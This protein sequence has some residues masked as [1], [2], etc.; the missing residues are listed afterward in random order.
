MSH[1]SLYALH[2]KAS[3]QLLD[4]LERAIGHL[5]NRAEINLFFNDLLTPT[6]RI[7]LSKRL[8]IILMIEKR[9][10]FSQIGSTLKVSES[11]I[12]AMRERMDRG[13]AGFHLIIRKLEKD[14]QVKKF[15]ENIERIFKALTPQPKVG[16]GQ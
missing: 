3:R 5:K 1:I 2:A 8:A 10:T 4:K 7:M 11:T 6:E 15:F 9:F 13:G 14:E 16:K 12:S